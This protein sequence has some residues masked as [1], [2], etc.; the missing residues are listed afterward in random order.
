MELG[1]LRALRLPSTGAATTGALGTLLP[2]S[3][4]GTPWP[5]AWIANSGDGW[6]LQR[7]G[8]SPRRTHVALGSGSWGYLDK[9]DGLLQPRPPPPPSS[10][11]LPF[12][13]KTSLNPSGDYF[14]TS[15]TLLFPRPSGD[16]RS[17]NQMTTVSQL[18][19]Y[20]LLPSPAPR[21]ASPAP[22]E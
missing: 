10:S 7:K 9:R 3:L 20:T 5:V 19:H 1:L 6:S 13:R 17:R 22:G 16:A 4:T 12:T 14:S 21:R 8:H 15:L 11:H 2:G 18:L